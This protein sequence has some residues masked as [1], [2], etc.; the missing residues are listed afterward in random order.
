MNT[1]QN[2]KPKHSAPTAQ[3]QNGVALVFVILMLAVAIG[4]VVISARMTLSGGK[5]STNDRDRQ[6][7]LQAAELALNDA[8]LDLMDVNLTDKSPNPVAGATKG[9]ACKFGNPEFPLLARVAGEC[10]KK[11]SADGNQHGLCAPSS[12][13]NTPAYQLVDWT[14]AEDNND[15]AYV[16]FG[17]F[18]G[19]QGQLQLATGIAPAK[20]PRY[21]IV[22]YPPQGDIYKYKVYA[23]GYG[24]NASTQVMLEGEFTK[25]AN[26]PE[27]HCLS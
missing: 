8:E 16:L 2:F 26:M 5:A 4:V 18:T 13:S 21:I 6:I 3:Q 17:E 27:K 15:R 22:E 9:R 12:G 23:L 7:A 24:A 11:S 10:G 19:R 20:A 1:P 25:A 14:E